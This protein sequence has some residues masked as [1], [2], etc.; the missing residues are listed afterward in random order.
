MLVITHVIP[1][2]G[3]TVFHERAGKFFKG[4]IVVGR[5]LMRF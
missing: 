3:E 4:K 1:A 2:D 5:D